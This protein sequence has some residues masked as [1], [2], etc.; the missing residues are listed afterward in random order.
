LAALSVLFTRFTGGVALI[1]PVASLLLAVL[2]REQVRRWPPILLAGAAGLIVEGLA[3]GPAW[4]MV[5]LMEA[6]RLAEP[7]V[8][9]LILCPV[10]HVG[11]D[12]QSVRGMAWFVAVAGVLA[13][14]LSGVP[15]AW[16]VMHTTGTAYSTSLV[17]WSAAHGLGA[18]IFTPICCALV[19][20]S[21]RE[22]LRHGHPSTAL[23]TMAL[24][25]L[26][27]LISWLVFAQSAMPLLFLPLLPIA[28]ATLHGG[29]AGAVLGVIV[30]AVI[31]AIHTVQGHGPV[32]IMHGSAAAHWLFLQAY[33]ACAALLVL[34]IAALLAQRARLTVRWRES[35]ARYRS[36]AE[37][38]GD[39]VTDVGPDG[40]I[41]YASPAIS[42][43]AGVH[44]NALI[45]RPARELVCQDDIDLVI[46]A[47]IEANDQ[48]GIASVVQYRGPADGE[49]NQRW[50]EA[51]MRALQRDGRLDG[52]LSSVR[53][54]TTRKTT[55]LDLA[56]AADLDPLTGLPNRRAFM[57]YLEARCGHVPTG[58]GI[59]SVA[60]L[61]LDHFK[62]VNDCHGHAV[63]DAV[64]K[65][66]AEAL[67]K[68]LR[69][70]D[71]VARIGGE[72][73]A[74]LICGAE[75]DAAVQAAERLRA[76]VGE[77]SFVAD[78]GAFRVT[79]SLGL[80]KLSNSRQDFDS[81]K[82]ADVA[83]YEAK[84]AGRNCLRVAG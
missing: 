84:A 63:G 61:D 69:G 76:A 22:K 62:T 11:V 29:R 4:Q 37:S 64:L 50:Y 78:Q 54:I 82:A 23:R 17:D 15:A 18:L 33:V 21:W 41:R 28:Y 70:Q 43:I 71:R 79:A 5:C 60:L 2:V 14:I 40:I 25:A 65:G 26:S 27:G 57:R 32:F 72:E 42:E 55:E 31:G 30:L 56:R 9:A 10:L 36:I 1:W 81:L 58:Q 52:V 39:A 51:S 13:P 38:L 68:L 24:P 35:E 8:A 34:P 45:G 16:V 19:S 66:V 67:A 3:V 53:D 47:Y 12:M 49:G 75:I 44:A 48:P 6:I 7:L 20:G 73:F 59:G 83:L 46:A 80:A 77:L 74:L